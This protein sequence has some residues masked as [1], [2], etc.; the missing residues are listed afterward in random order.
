LLRVEESLSLR[1]DH[2]DYDGGGSCSP[3]IP[4]EAR[5]LLANCFTILLVYV[6]HIDIGHEPVLGPLPFPDSRTRPR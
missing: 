6:R 1:N 3:E 2:A 4:Q 5:M